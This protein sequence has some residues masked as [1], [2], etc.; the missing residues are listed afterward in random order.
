MSEII[1]NAYQTSIITQLLKLIVEL[2]KINVFFVII[3]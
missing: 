2:A 1:T 3:V